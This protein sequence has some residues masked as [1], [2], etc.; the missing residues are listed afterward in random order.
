MWE[1][2]ERGKILKRYKLSEKEDN[3][4]WEKAKGC[5]VALIDKLSDIDN[6]LAELIINK[7]SMDDISA[8]TLVMSL[9]K[10]TLCRV[11]MIF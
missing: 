4:L 2:S 6:H 11:G 3:F 8:E 9:K 5:R 10:A 7:E 1:P